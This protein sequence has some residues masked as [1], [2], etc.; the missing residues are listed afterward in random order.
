MS[1][2]KF[3]YVSYDYTFLYEKKNWLGCYVP[4]AIKVAAQTI[5]FDLVAER[6][7]SEPS[8]QL[9]WA[10]F[11]YDDNS[12]TAAATTYTQSSSTNA[13]TNPWYDIYQYEK[14]KR[15][16]RANYF[17]RSNFYKKLRSRKR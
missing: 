4:T 10:D 12:T 3:Q 16:S 5:E 6:P 13:T 17:K 7:M 14:I 11:T 2:P 8:G 15:D 9:Y 1:K